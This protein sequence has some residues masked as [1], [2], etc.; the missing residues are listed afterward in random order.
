MTGEE[1]TVF[2][3]DLEDGEV[4]KWHGKIYKR[5]E[6]TSFEINCYLAPTAELAETLSQVI[7]GLFVP[8]VKD[9]GIQVFTYYP[10]NGHKEEFAYKHDY[11]SMTGVKVFFTPAQRDNFIKATGSEAAFR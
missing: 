7:C 9:E 3:V 8:S 4:K 11:Y 1:Q 10:T 6:Y 2:I 5:D